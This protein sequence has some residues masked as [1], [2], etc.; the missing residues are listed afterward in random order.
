MKNNKYKILVLSDLNETT[1]N[2]LKS[3]VSLA[4]IVDTDINFLY[5]KK[6]TEIVES[7]NQLSA[8]RTI[9]EDYLSTNNKIE[10]LIRSIS[11]NHNV[12]INHT[13]AI[14]NLKKEIGKYIDDDNPDIIVLGKRK[15]KALSFIGDNITQFILKKHK[16]TIIIVDDK[17]VL[18]LNKELHIGLFNSTMTNSKFTDTLINSTQKNILSFKINGNSPPLKEELSEKKVEYVFIEGD[19][20]LK[21]ISN[22][23]SK[24]KINL[25][26]V[27][28][29][30]EN[31]IKININDI[32]K[33][34][35]CSLLLTT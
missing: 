13:Y 12:N 35:D 34:I 14:G 3:S 2:V 24:R 26:F 20:V 1:S 16:G 27:D 6:P 28:R 7:E 17:N 15:S 19:R 31:L 25:L 8:M 32:I 5:V 11:E 33:T 9:N 30:K 29:K 4:K 18:E 22:Y 21:N 23:L 10:F